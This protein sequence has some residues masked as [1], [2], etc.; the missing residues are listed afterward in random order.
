MDHK[1]IFTQV[2]K[3]EAQALE[4]AASR[5]TE[6]QAQSLVNLYEQ[7]VNT[8]GSLIISGVGKSGHIG[9]KIAATFSSLG[10]PSF[11]LHPTEAMHGDLGRVTKL[12][13]IVL[14]SKSGTTEELLNMIPYVQIP[15]ERI[16]A[17]VGKVDSPIAH[18]SG[19]VLDASVEKEACINDLAPTTSTTL[20]LAMGDAM[21]V[22]YENVMGVSKEKFAV[23][24]P[25]GLLGKS[26]SLTVDRLMIKASDCPTVADTATLQDAILAMT[27]KPVGMCA[28]IS[29]AKMLG[30][31]VEGDIRR[32]FAK[33]ADAIKTPVKDIMTAKPTTVGSNTLAF[34]ALKIMENPARPL[35]V[36][37]VVDEGEFKGVLRLHDLF[38]AG[39]NSSL[40]K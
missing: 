3:T 38:K 21:A 36:A 12:D 5:F 17:L 37:P 4:L 39:F 18:K 9:T 8:G 30:I 23:N 29:G 35:N 16:V 10:L 6:T 27:Q 20:A 19:I 25:A 34:D 22:L 33:S 2:L 40:S 31:L 32:A 11:F 1:N 14:I 7:L 15:K 13:A 24:H 26:L 28:I